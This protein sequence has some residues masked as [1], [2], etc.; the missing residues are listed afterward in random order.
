MIGSL[1]FKEASIHAW[2]TRV[3]LPA[4]PILNL[5]FPLLKSPGVKESVDEPISKPVVLAP[6][7]S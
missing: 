7:S 5:Y 2:K 1:E 3:I 4:V 6:Q